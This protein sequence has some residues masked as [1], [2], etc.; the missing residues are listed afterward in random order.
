MQFKQAN[1]RLALTGIVMMPLLLSGCLMDES[2]SATTTV[3]P[4]PTSTNTPPTISG[5]PPPVVKVGVVYRF[6]PEASDQDNDT[7][8][9]EIENRPSWGTFNETTGELLGM[10][11]LGHVGTYNDITVTVSDGSDRTSL[12]PFSVSVEPASAPNMPPVISGTPPASVVAGNAYTFTP[13]AS[14]PDGDQLLFSVDNKPDWADF[15]S[16]NG[17]LSG[18]PTANDVANYNNISITVSD[19]SLSASTP[20]F[21]IAVTAE[22]AAP[23]ISGTPSATATVGQNYSFRP[24]ASDPDGD[25]L[26]FSISN[27]P[28]W[29]DFNSN[30]GALSGIPQQGDVGTHSNIDIT[31]SDGSLSA[32]LG[33]FTITVAA[34]PNNN[35]APTIS[36]TAPSTATVGAA[37]TFTPTA[38]DP[39][40]DTLTFSIQG[41]PSWASFDSSNGRLSGTPAAGDIGTDSN[42]RI[43]VS[44]GQLTANLPA[45]SITVQAAPNNNRAPT[46]SG[47]APSTVTVGAAYT[48]TPTA[49]DPDNDNLT[50]SIQGRPSWAS[51]NSNNGRLSGTP[52]AGDVGTDSN[53]RI[54]VSDGQLTANLPAFSITV[55]AAPNRAPTISGNPS[56]E[57]VVGSAY[58]FTPTA[59]DPDND[60]LTFSI[61]GR[62][63]WAS[64]NT[65]TGRLSGTPDAGD[66]GTSNNIRITVSDG[67]LSATLPAFSISVVAVTLGNVTLSW[68]P[69]TQNTDGSPLT[70]LAGFRIYYG[71]SQ[72]SYPNQIVLNNA[73]LTTYVVENLTPGTYF[74]VA[75]A[76]N[77]GGEE[78]DHSNV[79]QKVVASN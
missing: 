53:I 70:D 19:G 31:V 64:F 55:Q 28:D 2:E 37:Y 14:D 52:A 33:S 1:S 11:S 18:T 63:S 30:S 29:L 13:T 60:N 66:V 40:N 56:N 45:F 39:D 3:A 76:V 46:I 48:F 26:T 78:S 65:S 74:F 42:I 67:D 51:F 9:F 61:Q 24:T 23:T 44:D 4:P 57:V 77:S 72:G 38:S 36:G 5:S 59:S 12:A 68:T 15:N 20:A 25:T 6:Q 47:T 8:T 69:P 73:G 21:N 16:D 35:R 34:A 27:K 71:T 32:S 22:N 17:R 62:P 10:P 79:A 49:S 54:S 75:T 43:S 50:F 58:S 41:R 7:L